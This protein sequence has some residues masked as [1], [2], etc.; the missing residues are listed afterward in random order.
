MLTSFC[1]TEEWE[2]PCFPRPCLLAIWPKGAAH[3][4]L[5]CFT[6]VMHCVLYP[7]LEYD[8][9]ILSLDMVGNADGE[10]SLAIVDPCPCVLD[11]RIPLMYQE[12]ARYAL[13]QR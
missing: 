5:P 7:R 8:L 4:T 6:Q 1:G 11:R 13:F 9:P 2:Q 12:T 10:V 3:Q